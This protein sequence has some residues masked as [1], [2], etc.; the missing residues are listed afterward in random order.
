MGSC[1]EHRGGKGRHRGLRR[2]HK[3]GMPGPRSFE[4]TPD[5]EIIGPIE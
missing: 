4:V 1:G 5:G 3:H 2:R